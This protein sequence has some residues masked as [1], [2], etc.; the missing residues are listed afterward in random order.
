MQTDA[1]AV[2]TTPAARLER[3]RFCSRCG[4]LSDVHETHADQLGFERVCSHCGMGL[5]LTCASGVMKAPKAAFV[6]AT[7][8]LKVSAVSEAGE[9]ILGSEA[10][11]LGS[12]L[13]NSLSSPAGDDELTFAVSQAALGAREAVRLPITTAS[14]EARRY[15]PLRAA[16]ASCEPPRAALL[17]LEP[18]GG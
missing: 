12:S 13:L 7:R 10:S 4:R 18:I 15:G 14:P 1:A 6:V 5:L 16:I 17:V 8:E 11:L 2:R 9:R 3:T